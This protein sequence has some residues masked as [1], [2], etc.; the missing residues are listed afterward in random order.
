MLIRNALGIRSSEI[1]PKDV[2]MNRR[3]FLATATLIGGGLAVNARAVTY[4]GLIKSPL[5]TNEKPTSYRD[6]TTYNNYYEFG[7]S[8]EEP[9]QKAK[10]LKTSPWT[11]SV[12]GA[13]AK[14]RKF[15]LD[16]I[17]KIAPLEERI[18]RHRC[19]EAWSIVVPDRLLAERADQ[20]GRADVEGEV[21]GVRKP[22]RPQADACRALCWISS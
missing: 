12:E 17:M 2:Y 9:A 4:N 5:S 21:R 6:A 22:I 8:K 11:V 15:D 20:A 19:V 10:T 3:R 14:P 7:T 16:A 13:V 18:Y 1:T